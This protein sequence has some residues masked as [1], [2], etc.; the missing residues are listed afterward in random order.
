MVRLQTERFD[1]IG[2][3]NCIP[4]ELRDDLALALSGDAI[5]HDDDDEEDENEAEGVTV[6][7]CVCVRH[8]TLVYRVTHLH[9][10]KLSVQG[11]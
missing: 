6:I 5:D 7:P 4:Q 10:P 1:L 11:R 9:V 8:L 3:P 2:L